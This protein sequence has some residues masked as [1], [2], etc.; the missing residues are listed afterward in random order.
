[1]STHIFF[2]A[3]PLLFEGE[4]RLLRAR[5][6]CINPLVRGA[7][8]RLE[9]YG[10]IGFLCESLAEAR[11]HRLEV[12]H[13]SIV[14]RLDLRNEAPLL[15]LERKRHLPLVLLLNSCEL[16]LQDLRLD[17]TARRFLLAKCAL[18][19]SVCLRRGGE[20]NLRRVQL[21]CA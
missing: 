2:V 1:M 14:A 9:S 5:R 4:V 7:Q 15:L 3:A 13:L 10:L 21:L 19:L 16:A 17:S 18:L 6:N 12:P 11:H 20:L 8:L